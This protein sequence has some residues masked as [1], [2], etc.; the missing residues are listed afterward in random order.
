MKDLHILTITEALKMDNTR[1]VGEGRQMA[2]V[3]TKVAG[4]L[5]SRC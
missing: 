4:S 3:T 2:D 1:P 5:L